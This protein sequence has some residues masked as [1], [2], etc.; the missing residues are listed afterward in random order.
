MPLSA[1]LNPPKLGAFRQLENAPPGS[2]SAFQSREG[3]PHGLAGGNPKND[4]VSEPLSDEELLTRY[5]DFRESE[6]FSELFRRHSGPLYLYLARYLKDATMAED[7]LQEAFLRIHTRC[8]LYRDGWPAKPWMYAVATHLAVD[9]LRRAKRLSTGHP[10]AVFERERPRSRVE[11]PADTK[12]GPFAELEE[13]E[14]RKW[15]RES[16]TRLPK[17]QSQIVI[18]ACYQGKTYGEIVGTLGVPLGTVKSRMHCAIERL[19]AMAQRYERIG[20]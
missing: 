6:V 20:R 12:V 1:T 7:V 14:R 11:L 17:P 8:D 3:F 9:S 13:C 2:G 15:L 19:R 18:L 16:V 5:R 10:D 4:P